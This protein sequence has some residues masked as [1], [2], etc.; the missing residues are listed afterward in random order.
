MRLRE[1]GG[2]W[3]N[4]SELIVKAVYFPNIVLH[5][6]PQFILFLRVLFY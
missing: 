4:I 3:A 1:N 2:F 5:I 6:L